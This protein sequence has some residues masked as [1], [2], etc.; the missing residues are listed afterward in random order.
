MFR[1]HFV[2]SENRNLARWDYSIN[3]FIFSSLLVESH[4]V[5]EFHFPVYIAP[6]LAVTSS[7]IAILKDVNSIQLKLDSS[8]PAAAK[9]R[10]RGNRTQH[11]VYHEHVASF[12]AA[13]Y[14]IICSSIISFAC[15]RPSPTLF[16][17]R[18][19]FFSS[20]A[21]RCSAHGVASLM[22]TICGQLSGSS[23]TGTGMMAGPGRAR[24]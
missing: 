23:S 5:C 3:E 6:C 21:S 10:R 4:A 17:F 24:G 1:N 14:F 19:V 18:G 7:P 22:T 11:S 15:R 8:A 2:P 16:S 12:T 20:S 9:F 13:Q